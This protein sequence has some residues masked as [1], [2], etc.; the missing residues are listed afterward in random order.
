M[1]RIYKTTTAMVTCLSLI[2]PQL[3]VAQDQQTQGADEQ[4][5]LPPDQQQEA[6]AGQAQEPQ[7]APEPAAEPVPAPAE[8]PQAQPQ[9]E[10]P[11]PGDPQ[12]QG[13]SSASESPAQETAA[14]PA[15]EPQTQDEPA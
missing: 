9:A 15:A 5:I 10:A 7:S 14:E 4:V 1:R 6:E 13:A 12:V 2:A 8:Q 3:A 11:S